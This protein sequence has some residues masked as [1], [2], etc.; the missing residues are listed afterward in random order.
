MNRA[1]LEFAIA[2]YQE[3]SDVVKDDLKELD[4]R[5]AVLEAVKAELDRAVEMIP[6]TSSS[7]RN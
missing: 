7:S 4:R 1:D 3:Q 5:R 6:V 2:Q